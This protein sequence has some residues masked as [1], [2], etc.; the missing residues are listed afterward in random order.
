[1]SRATNA[2][3]SAVGGLA[4]W[5]TRH[6]KVIERPIVADDD[7]GLAVIGRPPENVLRLLPQ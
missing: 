5:L 3:K 4:G 6:P 2:L 7:S 1:M